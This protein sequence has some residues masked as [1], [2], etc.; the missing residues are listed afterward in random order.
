MHVDNQVLGLFNVGFRSVFFATRKLK[1]SRLRVSLN[2]QMNLLDNELANKRTG[3]SPSPLYNAS[4]RL[5]C[6]SFLSNF[7]DVRWL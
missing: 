5:F 6:S 2:Y 3:Q 4:T 1:R 7:H